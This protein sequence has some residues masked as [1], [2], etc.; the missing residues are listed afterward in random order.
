[1]DKTVT[2]LTHVN[3]AFESK[4]IEVRDKED[5]VYS[6]EIVSQLPNVGKKHPQYHE[7]MMRRESA[8]RFTKYLQNKKIDYCLE[9]GCGNGWFSNLIANNTTAN[10]L[11]LDINLTELKQASKL[12]TKENLS[13]AYGDIFHSCFKNKFDLVVFNA[14][15]Q[16]FPDFK[17]VLDQL[18]FILTPNGEIHIID[19]PFYTSALESK[20]AKERSKVYFDKT[21]V[22]EMVI[23]YHHHD[24][25]EIKDFD[26]LYSSR[27][28]IWKRI[29]RKRDSPFGWYRWTNKNATSL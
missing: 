3:D 18:K 12:F 16:Y 8:I 20:K 21:G 9:I 5:R 23:H 7:W 19:S 15:I 25:T 26:I 1:M 4:Y 6:N 27:K 24:K 29:T 22:P 13:F 2:F 17:A 28:N 10:V 14:S 11:G